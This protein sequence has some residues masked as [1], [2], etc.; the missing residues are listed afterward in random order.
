MSS[1]SKLVGSPPAG[2][3]VA[4]PVNPSH[5]PFQL[6]LIGASVLLIICVHEA[7]P[8]YGHIIQSRQFED[9]ASAPNENS[10][11]PVVAMFTTIQV[12]FASPVN[13]QP[14]FAEKGFIDGFENDPEVNSTT[15]PEP[16]GSI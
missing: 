4:S 10:N 9:A 2:G 14:W 11:V 7:G 6:H 1:G 15:D 16:L 5:A 8:V 13:K 12:L 3:G